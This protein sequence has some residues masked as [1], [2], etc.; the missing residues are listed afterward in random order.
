MRWIS[1]ASKA[2]SKLSLLFASVGL[3]AMTLIILWQVFARYILNSSPSWSEQLSLYILVWTVMLSSAAGIR[4][5]F[6][7]RISVF[8][9][10]LSGRTRK[11]AIIA[12]HGIV[13]LIGIVLFVSGVE[14]TVKT[15]DTE[16]PTLSISRGLALIP[17]PISGLMISLFS[18]EH[19]IAIMRNQEVQASWN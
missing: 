12:C 17:I 1:Q 3:C 5:G 7:I 18:M 11:A 8:Q 2:L 10:Q 14:F 15:W 9:D 19:V 4:E 6:H 13:L 16:I